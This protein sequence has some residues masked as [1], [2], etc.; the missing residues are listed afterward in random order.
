MNH[1]LEGVST[2]ISWREPTV[3]KEQSMFNWKSSST[4]GKATYQLCFVCSIFG[5]NRVSIDTYQTLFALNKALSSTSFWWGGV[6]LKGVTRIPISHLSHMEQLRLGWSWFFMATRY[7]E[8]T[9][10][11]MKSAR[12]HW[13]KY[14]NFN[15]SLAVMWLRWPNH[16]DHRWWGRDPSHTGGAWCARLWFWGMVGYS[17]STISTNRYMIKS[18]LKIARW[19]NP[20]WFRVSPFF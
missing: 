18:T 7:Q 13:S 8:I 15:T 5:N 2:H 9:W 10:N 12:S 11:Q 1:N 19:R 3:G 6:A 14:F 20:W 17:G 4:F 16:S